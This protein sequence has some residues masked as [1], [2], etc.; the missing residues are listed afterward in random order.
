MTLNSENLKRLDR[1]SNIKINQ[2]HESGG[3]SNSE[4]DASQ[5]DEE[6]INCDMDVDEDVN[7]E[8]ESKMGNR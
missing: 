7:E 8:L 6:F 3:S 4:S 1:L 2:D 5:N